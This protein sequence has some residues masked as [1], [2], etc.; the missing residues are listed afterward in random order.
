MSIWLLHYIGEGV[1][2]FVDFKIMHEGVREGVV[3]SEDGGG[4]SLKRDGFLGLGYDMARS[5]SGWGT[6]RGRRSSGRGDLL[7]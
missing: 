7:R 1:H 2:D 5:C 3:S 4:S 6:R